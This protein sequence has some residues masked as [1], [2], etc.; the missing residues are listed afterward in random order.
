M[1]LTAG[2]TEDL[3]RQALLPVNVLAV[4]TVKA[5]AIV[6]VTSRTAVNAVT[7]KAITEDVIEV[8]ALTQ[9]IALMVRIHVTSG[10]GLVHTHGAGCIQATASSA[11]AH[12]I[13]A[14]AASAFVSALRERVIA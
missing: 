8:L 12:T 11:V 6:E 13:L 7:D 3:L 1:V 10:A 4:V 2:L 9:A 14:T 5:V